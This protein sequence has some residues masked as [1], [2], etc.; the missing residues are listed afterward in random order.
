MKV[1]VVNLGGIQSKSCEGLETSSQI[2]KD[3]IENLRNQAKIFFVG[4]TEKK[5]PIRAIP[6]R[7]VRLGMSQLIPIRSMLSGTMGVEPP[8]VH[9]N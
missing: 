3:V 8:P 9:Q 6:R 1:Q 5:D 7:N 2:L 4:G